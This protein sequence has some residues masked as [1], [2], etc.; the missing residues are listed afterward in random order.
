MLK[1]RQ[2]Q[3]SQPLFNVEIPELSLLL[4]AVPFPTFLYPLTGKN[5][6]LY[7][8]TSSVAW[9][10]RCTSV[11]SVPHPC[12]WRFLWWVPIHGLLY[13]MH[14]Q[15]ARLVS[16]YSIASG[17]TLCINKTPLLKWVQANPDENLG[18]IQIACWRQLF[19]STVCVNK[20]WWWCLT[21][22]PGLFSALSSLS[23]FCQCLNSL[24]MPCC[25]YTLCFCV[26]LG[27]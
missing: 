17:K 13:L 16:K 12:R 7:F 1:S 27:A 11:S 18:I 8:H 19:G 10:V 15:C 4:D 24:M 6:I 5:A 14:V 3:Y 9:Q 23:L 20:R 25:S 21:I 22:H 26:A 2:V